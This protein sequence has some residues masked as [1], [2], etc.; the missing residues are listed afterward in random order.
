MTQQISVTHSD[1][2][3]TER[4]HGVLEVTADIVIKRLLLVNVVFLG[5]AGAGDRQWVLIDAGL[6]GT[7]GT[8]AAA[9]ASRF[10]ASSRP[11]AIILTHGH[12][13]HFGAL[14][15]LAEQWDVPVYAHPHEHPYLNGQASYPPPDPAV[16]GGLMSTLSPLYPRGPVNV[17]NR[18]RALP[19]D[20]SLP[21]MPG[22]RWLHTPGHAVGHC[23]FW[24]EGDR[25]LI[26]GDA[27][28]TTAQESAYAVAVQEPEIH[29]PPMYYTQDWPSARRSVETLA[30]LDPEL[31]VTGHGRP[32]MG[33]SMRVA[34]HK[35]AAE[36]DTVAHPPN[37]KYVEHP[38]HAE[39]G[40][41]YV[42]T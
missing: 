23:S 10:G 2:A 36:F 39:D 8:I 15:T 34:L 4:E 28:I 38:L 19:E 24:R 41:A 26:A 32:M 20:G 6:P 3:G 27:V 22:W 21:L 25:T 30:A 31:L 37:A 9:A 14:E 11:G 16:G 42:R 33:A 5:L 1:A 18:L 40:T 17:G 35:L 13:D 29:G 7:A 12:F